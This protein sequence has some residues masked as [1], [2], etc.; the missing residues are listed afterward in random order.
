MDFCPGYVQQ[1]ICTFILAD[2]ADGV[3][4]SS[5]GDSGGPVYMGQTALGLISGESN[6]TDLIYMAQNYL[7][8]LN[9]HVKIN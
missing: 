6:G 4:L 2:N 7:D 9:L 8:K 1:V 5:P 3:D